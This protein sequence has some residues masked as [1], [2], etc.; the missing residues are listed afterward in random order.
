MST[1]SKSIPVK[2]ATN[3]VK[4]WQSENS[5]TNKNGDLIHAKAFLISAVDLLDCLIEM[6]IIKD[7]SCI[8]TS[9]LDSASVRAYMAIDRPDTD[10]TPSAETER[11]VL[12]ATTKDVDS[13][14]KTV[15][16]DI[17]EGYVIKNPPPH[18]LVGT[19][20]F[21]FTKPCPNNCDIESPLY[22]P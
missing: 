2:E 6:Q 19:G 7:E 9:L 4:K 1:K 15:H 5:A 20:T 8:N 3:R 18:K 12:V 11:L 17:I 14:N 22:N 13:N 10:N 16:R 21:D